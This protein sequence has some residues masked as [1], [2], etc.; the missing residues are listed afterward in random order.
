MEAYI[1]RFIFRV[2]RDYGDDEVCRRITADKEFAKHVAVMLR[3]YANPDFTKYLAEGRKARLERLRAE[4]VKA[5]DGLE[6]AANLYRRSEP[7]TAALMHERAA[8]LQAR[9]PQIDELLD[10]KRHGRFRDH[11]ILDVTRQEI[12]KAV[13]PITDR[14]LANLTNAAFLAHGIYQEPVTEEMIRRNLANLRVRNPNWNP[15]R[16]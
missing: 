1:D 14:T 10:V 5:V 6:A 11:G 4:H 9:I 16:Q 15:S 8:Q 2:N 13:G 3:R 7:E 12:E